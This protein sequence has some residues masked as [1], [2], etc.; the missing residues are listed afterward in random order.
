M[1]TTGLANLR[2]WSAI[3]TGIGIAVDGSDLRVTVA[4]VRPSGTAIP[5]TAVISQFRTRPAAEWGAIYHDFIK[6]LGASHLPAAA[7]LPRHELI[8]R[9]LAMPGVSGRDLAPAIAFQADSLHPYGDEE[10]SYAWARVSKSGVLIAVVRCETIERYVAL[11][12]EAGIKIASFTFS[13]AAV[14]S[15]ARLLSPAPDPG[16]LAVAETGEGVEIYGESPAKPLFSASFDMPVEKAVALA[17]AELRL[18]EGT[19]PMALAEL[20]PQPKTFPADY[21]SARGVFAYAAALAA[22]CP[23]LALPLNLL[24]AGHRSSASRAR[25]IPAAVGAVVLAALLTGLGALQPVEDSE[26]KAALEAEIARY[27]PM[28]NKAVSLDRSIERMRARSK[29]IGSFRRRTNAD[30]DACAELTKILRPP[31]WLNSIELSPTSVS[32]S[33]QT[34]QSENLLKLIDRSPYFQG[35]EFTVPLTPQAKLESFRIR[36]LRKGTAQ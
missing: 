8:V 20:L 18:P 5:G 25:L 22:A 4:R 36:S 23:R 24:P 12:A 2:K 3:G 26:Y 21:D 6:R 30:L 1:M 28:A 17:S 9:Q 34:D 31:T 7:V 33:G 15:A 29:L 35:S 19:E 10:A 16:F 11:F 32:L 13:A 14:Y 27:Q